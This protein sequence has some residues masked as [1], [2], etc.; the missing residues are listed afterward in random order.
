[1]M[2]LVSHYVSNNLPDPE[3]EMADGNPREKAKTSK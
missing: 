2:V 1:M 3:G